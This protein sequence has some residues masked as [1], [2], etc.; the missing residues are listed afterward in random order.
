MNAKMVRIGCACAIGIASICSSSA[1]P[2]S[3][4]TVV[5]V[6]DAVIVRPISFASTVVGSALFTLSLP[7]T[8]PMKK[9]KPVADM[10]VVKPAQAT[11]KRPLG[12]M[13]ALAD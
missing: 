7:V 6:A 13:D 2:S 9:T 4:S 5:K 11:F 8:A 10:L 12:D 3:P 1:A